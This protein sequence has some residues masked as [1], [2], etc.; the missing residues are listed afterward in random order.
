MSGRFTRDMGLR[1]PTFNSKGFR[2]EPVKCFVVS[3]LDSV[4][5]VEIYIILTRVI[6]SSFNSFLRFHTNTVEKI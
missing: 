3:L 5:C 2:D 4:F 1:L 6:I